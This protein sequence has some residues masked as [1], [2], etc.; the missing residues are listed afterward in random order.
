MQWSGLLNR[1]IITNDDMPFGLNSR[2]GYGQARESHLD[3]WTPT[4]KNA[5]YPRLS[6]GKNEYNQ[7]TSTFWVQNGS[8]LRLKHVELSYDLP[9]KWISTLKMSKAQIFATGYNLLTITGLK[10]RDPEMPSFSVMPNTKSISLGVNI[11]F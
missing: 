5:E 3:R 10:D 9:T 11:E 4:N 1:D 2:N 8:F 6:V 7:R